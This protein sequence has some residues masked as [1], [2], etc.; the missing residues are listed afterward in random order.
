MHLGQLQLEVQH[1]MGVERHQKVWEVHQAAVAERHPGEGE[2]PGQ[3]EVVVHIPSNNQEDMSDRVIGNQFTV[4][5][6]TA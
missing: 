6:L 2:E 5:I 3:K 4:A 1:L